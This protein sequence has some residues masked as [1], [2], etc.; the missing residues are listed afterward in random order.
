[1]GWWGALSWV[2]HSWGDRSQD[3]GVLKKTAMR[4]ERQP[5]LELLYLPR[6][7][8]GVS[9]WGTHTWTGH[10][11]VHCQ[12]ASGCLPCPL[13]GLLVIYFSPLSFTFSQEN[14]S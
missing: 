3:E 11:P 7:S 12:P 10:S 2:F 13:D 14:K 8:H 9:S 5:H 1:M 4:W 6:L